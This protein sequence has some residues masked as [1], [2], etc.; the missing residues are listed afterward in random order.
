MQNF[1]EGAKRITD[2][3]A[4]LSCGLERISIVYTVY[5]LQPCM[6]FDLKTVN[7]VFLSHGGSGAEQMIQWRDP[8]GQ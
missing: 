4:C 3:R 2:C 8:L 6:K 5:R 1:C 7:D